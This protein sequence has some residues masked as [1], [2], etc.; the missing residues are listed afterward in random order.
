M[1]ERA[2]GC[3]NRSTD[4]AAEKP[5]WAQR[6]RGGVRRRVASAGACAG[7]GDGFLILRDRTIAIF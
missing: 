2:A 5:W 3:E 1:R 7:A 4:A 6:Q